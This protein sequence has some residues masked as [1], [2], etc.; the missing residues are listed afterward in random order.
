MAWVHVVAGQLKIRIRYS[1]AVYNNFVC[2]FPS[3]KQRA[4]LELTAQKI[5]DVRSKY[6]DSTL[7]DLYAPLTMPEELLKAHKANDATVC[8]AYG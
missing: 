3:E 6:P 7:T 5:L 4:K 2:P 8:E 1:P